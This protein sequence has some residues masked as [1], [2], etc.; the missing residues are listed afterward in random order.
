MGM[1]K[2][3]LVPID[4]G[5]ET[6]WK[7]VLPAAVEM[8]QQSGAKLHVMTV[9]PTFGMPVVNVNYFPDDFEEKALK[10]G[11]EALA[12]LVA[13]QVPADVGA[14]SHVAHGTIYSEILAAADKLGCDTIVLASHRPGM[15]DY[16]IGP[17]AAR[18]ARHAKQSVF[19]IRD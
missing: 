18:V 2:S 14:K 8:A 17:N 1:F 10:E 3:I 5:V 19:I 4:L 9:M 12:K 6:S 11:G 13:E 7:K 16:L 15:Q